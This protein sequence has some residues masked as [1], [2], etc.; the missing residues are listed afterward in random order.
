MDPLQIYRN[1]LGLQSATFALIEHEEGLVAVVYE[2]AQ[3]SGERLIL[4]IAPNAT[5]YLRE[6][7]FLGELAGSVPVPRVVGVVEPEEGVDGAILMERLPGKLLERVDTGLAHELGAAL[8]KVHNHR[9]A[10]YGDPVQGVL[11]ADPRPYFTR[12]FEEGLEECGGHLPQQMLKKAEGYFR[13]HLHL[14]EGVDGP[15]VAHR[16][17]R[18]GNLIVES[19]RLQ[20]II[21]WAGARASFAEEDL[22]SIE[23]GEWLGPHKGAFLAG[24]GAL[25]PLP[26]YQPLTPLLRLNRAIASVGFVLKRG[27]RESRGAHLY[28]VNIRFLKALLGG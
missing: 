17:F 5:H 3:P 26:D 2:I 9:L 10:G 15:C 6:V 13:S 8:A 1:Y 14:L 12:K 24:Y 23:A 28:Q 22:C 18:P 4:K 11:E 25:R 27:I 21:D 7:Y 20:G 19:D 16:D